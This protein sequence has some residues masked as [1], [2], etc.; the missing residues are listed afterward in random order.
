MLAGISQDVFL[1]EWGAPEIQI[2]LDN[3]EGYYKRNA[4]AVETD[5]SGEALHSVWIYKG[6]NR[7][8]FFTRK[9]LVSH[10][11]WTEFKEKR[12][13][14]TMEMDPKSFKKPPVFLTTTLSMVA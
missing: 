3:L 4:V 10:F 11:K 14:S 1:K 7:V 12:V 13:S 2:N 9:K 8:F 5:A 6:K